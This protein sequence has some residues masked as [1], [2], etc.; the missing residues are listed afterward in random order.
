M[1]TREPTV[2]VVDD[3]PA[4]RKSLHRLVESV[5]LPVKTFTSARAFKEAYRPDEP[6]CL[7]VDVRMPGMSGLDLQQ[8]LVARSVHL[9]VIVISGHGDVSM[10]VRALKAGAVDFIEKPYNPQALL[11]LVQHCLEV[12]AARRRDEVTRADVER[13]V[14]SLTLREREVMDLVVAGES[15]RAIAQQL[16]IARRTI[17]VHRAQVMH[18]MEAA[19]VPDLVRMGDIITPRKIRT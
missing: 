12:D 8:D 3:D 14:N 11:D 15:N 1:T 4:V 2:F 7:V 18:K 10:A 6:G 16:G 17:E 13:R 9:P 5:D 19:S